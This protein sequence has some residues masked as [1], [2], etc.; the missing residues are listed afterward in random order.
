MLVQRA[1]AALPKRQ[2]SS[3]PIVSLIMSIVRRVI[4]QISFAVG[5]PFGIF[6]LNLHLTTH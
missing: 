3:V 5:G 4:F 1:Q 2:T 6:N